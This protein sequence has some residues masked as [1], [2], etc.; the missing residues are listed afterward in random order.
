LKKRGFL[1]RAQRKLLLLAQIGTN[2]VKFAGELKGRDR[3]GQQESEEHGLL[4][5]HEPT[6]PPW[7][8]KA[9]V[10]GDR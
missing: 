9:E 7:P 4:H 8:V 1:F 5:A 6:P 2:P 10:G 3:E